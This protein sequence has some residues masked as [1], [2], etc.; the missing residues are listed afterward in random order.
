[1][2]E[3]DRLGQEVLEPVAVDRVGVPAADLHEAQGAAQRL[4]LPMDHRQQRLRRGRVAGL[5]FSAGVGF[6]AA[7][8]YWRTDTG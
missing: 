4:G 1:M 7:V 5:Y 8:C 6:G 2:D 3:L